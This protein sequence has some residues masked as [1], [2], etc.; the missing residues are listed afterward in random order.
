MTA[1]F[2][3]I[4][5]DI[6]MIL[7]LVFLEERVVVKENVWSDC[8]STKNQQIFYGQIIEIKYTTDLYFEGYTNEIW[9]VILKIITSKSETYVYSEESICFGNRK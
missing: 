7:F 2:T 4:H 8:R 1:S 6:I 3:W 5:R 9:N